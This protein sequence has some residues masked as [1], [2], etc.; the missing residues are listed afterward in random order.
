MRGL[1]GLIPFTETHAAPTGLEY[2]LLVR[3]YNDVAPPA[4][5]IDSVVC[6]RRSSGQAGRQFQH[7]Q[8]C[9]RVVAGDSRAP[10]IRIG[11]ED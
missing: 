6:H 8:P 10:M 7:A 5:G 1:T 11:S 4:L 3:F 9:Q 2:L